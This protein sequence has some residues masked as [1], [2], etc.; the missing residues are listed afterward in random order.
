MSESHLSSDNITDREG[1][2]RLLRFLSLELRRNPNVWENRD[3]G[4]FLEGLTSWIEDMDGCYQNSG[5]EQPKNIN[6]RFMADALLAA[7]S[8][9]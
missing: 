6:W 4:S 7:R 3:L 2:L 5:A 9:E 8:Y 1:F